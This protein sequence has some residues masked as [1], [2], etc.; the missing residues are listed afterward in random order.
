MR[1]LSF[2]APALLAL[3]LPTTPAADSP[4]PPPDGWRTDAPR[5]EIRPAFSYD[6]R[7]GRSGTRALVITADS[8]EGLHGCW[9]KDFPVTGGK[10]YRVRAYRKTTDVPTPRKTGL[11]RVTWLD[12]KGNKVTEDRPLTTGYLVGGKTTAETEHPTDGPADAK[13]WAEVGGT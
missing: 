3:T 7:G 10:H 8:R 1:R 12:A 2:L 13:G 6:P 9:V 11:A 4:A 5:D